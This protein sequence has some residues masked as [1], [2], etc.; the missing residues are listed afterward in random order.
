[1][2]RRGAAGP[3]SREVQ[4]FPEFYEWFGRVMPS[5]ARR[6]RISPAPARS[7]YKGHALLQADLDNLEPALDGASP[8]E[9]F[10]PAISPSSVE[11]WHTEPLLQDRRRNI[12]SPSPRRCAR[13][14]GRSSTRASCSRSTTPGW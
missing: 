7:A 14:T 9:V 10:V 2:R 1:M 13:S 11:H 6:P 5:P 3:G 12:S 4:A 8:A